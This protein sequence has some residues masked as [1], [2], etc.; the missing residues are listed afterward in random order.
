MSTDDK[1][2]NIWVDTGGTFTD[3]IAIT[4]EGQKIRTKV[5]SNSSLRGSIE[6]VL[7]P[8]TFLISQ[9]WSAPLNF[10]KGFTFRLLNKACDDM[11]VIHFDPEE[12]LLKVNSPL[13]DDIPW[14]GVGFEVITKEEAPILAA[15][16]VTGTL[17]DENLPPMNMRLATTRGTN[18]LL[19]RNGSPTALFITKGFKDLLEIGTQQRPDLFSLN[20]EKPQSLYAYT[21]EVPERMDANG[22]V[23]TQLDLGAMEEAVDD[24]L[25]KGV[26]SISVALMNSYKNPD[27]EKELK[28]WLS[29]KG[30]EYISLSSEL[31]RFIKILPRAET[32]LVN[33]YLDPIIREYI[34]SVKSCLTDGNLFVMT[35]A[36]GLVSDQR[37]YPKD[38]LLSGPAGG[39]VGASTVGKQAGFSDIISFDMG[40]T[41]TDVAR[42]GGDYEY[43]F[44]HKV[45]DA[46]LVAPA[47][48]IETVAAGGGSVCSFD[49]YTLSVGPE[50]AGAYPGPACY[51]AGGPL[52]ITDVN[53][54]L[55]RL[56][57]ENFGIPIS[58]QDAKNQLDQIVAK[59]S[60]AE[61]KE[62]DPKV[63]LEGFLSIAN[64]RMADAIKKISLR[65]GYNPQ[66]Y[67][68]VSFGGAGSQH[69]CAIA[70][71]LE[72]KNI[73]VP[74]E[75]GVLSAHGLGHAVVERFAEKQLL[76]PLE[77]T[78]SELE[79][80][81]SD[82]EEQ[83]V[84]EL[85]EQNIKNDEIF[86]RRR[87]VFLRVEGQEST[88]SVEYDK[89]EKVEDLFYGLYQERYG[90]WI[91]GL[92]IE[93][94]SLRVVASTQ[95]TIE[96][97][98]EPPSTSKLL[99]VQSKDIWFNG[100]K[101]ETELFD[102]AQLRPG[103]LISGPA[104]VLDPLSTIVI[105][106]GWEAKVDMNLTLKLE[107]SEESSSL[108]SFSQPEAIKLELFTNRFTS[109]AEEMGEM[110]QR[111]ALSVNVKER[112]DFSCAL[113]NEKGELVVNAPHIPVHL[114][115]IGMCVRS[116][117]EHMK[118]EPGDVIVTNHPAYGG[119]HLPDVTVITPVFVDEDQ[120]I[121]YA[122]SRAH[123]SEIG[124]T[125]PGSMPPDATNLAQ[126]GVT[127][128]PMYLVKNG[129]PKW[130]D[131]RNVLLGGRYP[132]RNVE[133]NIADLRA[134]VAANRRG[135][136]SLE[137]LVDLYGSD[138]VRH[139][140]NEL[141]EH[142]S[143]MSKSMLREIENNVYKSTEYLD[144]GTPLVAT[145][146]VK[147]EHVSIDFTGTGDVHPNNL[148]ATPAIVNSVV[149]YVLRMLISKPIPLNEGLLDP[150]TIHLP[151]CL[152]NPV[153]DEDPAKCPAVVGGNIEISQRLVD[154]LLKPF[155]RAACSQGTMN[156]ILFGN[157][158]FGYYETVGGG[159]GAGPDFEG[160][161]AV[162][163]HMTNTRGTDPEVFEYRYPVR[164]DLYQ[165]RKDSGGKGQH[166]GGDGIVREMT[167]LEP[168]SL[169]VL[170]QHR[171]EG[172]YGL[173]DGE[174][175]KTG[176]QWV[177]RQSGEKEELSSVDGRQLAAGDR[178]ILHTPGGG[179]YGSLETEPAIQKNPKAKEAT[180]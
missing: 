45:G 27:H 100:E 80:L 107:K 138:E 64:E 147:D 23:L 97:P 168:V 85:K 155:N 62:V 175:G 42:Y 171:K 105:E 123:H 96:N 50:S 6:Q 77:E 106:P 73:V 72:M 135:V 26:K 118:I 5:L 75:A 12:S 10:V 180:V 37:F 57:P 89:D 3:C 154:T 71:R 54:L 112:L 7:S 145:L 136:Q 174:P 115:A 121:G 101:I 28:N 93:V 161:H 178:F 56:A 131:I 22:E 41:S 20:I 128:S 24:L 169:S 158:N 65:K 109:I 143:S 110:L 81:F 170:T 144:D 95:V 159:T 132:T 1:R 84:Q 163:Q 153:F 69:C 87:I 55:G 103:H 34:S 58:I 99:A 167:F 179:G 78:E 88:L 4:P 33:A 70:D 82:L 139:Y 8:D 32:T 38:S 67:A 151:T 25:R 51:G 124:G 86:I 140:M 173:K 16:L 83:A 165:V 127:I 152:L 76:Q 47:L 46:H 162:H 141:K 43:A 92:S 2:W 90:H 166:T 111:T 129:D 66:D 150:V 11:T 13:P 142:A 108:I 125:R 130:E 114:G 40:G 149:M 102:R 9:D 36:G 156:N 134:A 160:C 120:L 119:A 39:V 172:P 113:L 94:E 15:R 157:D 116:I 98:D 35:S 53:L 14:E 164:L 17:L 59:V 61:A 44:E 52:T 21:I 146:T 176:H 137:N 122:A 60:E 30:F 68:L 133:E 29:Q 148:N 49:G 126:E 31:S 74:I 19:E 63:V 91:D 18:A 48:S 79:K 104:L 177:V 117:K